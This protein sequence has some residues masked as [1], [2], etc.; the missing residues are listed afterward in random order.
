MQAPDD[1]PEGPVPSDGPPP[2]E[3]PPTEPSPTEK[4]AP[5]A[6]DRLRIEAFLEMLGAEGGV[7]DNTLIAYATDLADAAI[8]LKPEGGLATAGADGLSRYLAALE[9]RGLAPWTQARRL[10]ALR[11][12]FRFMVSDGRRPD[13]PTD[14]LDAPRRHRPLPRMLS[15]DDVDRLINAAHA[16]EGPEGRRLAAIVE[17]LYATGL[18]V[19]ELVTLPAAALIRDPRVLMVRGKGGRDRIVPLGA[20]ARAAAAA[21]LAVRGVFL[22]AD[23]KAQSFLFPSRAAEGHLTRQ[24]IGQLLKALALD[25]GIAPERVSP[26]VLRHAFASHLLSGGADLRVVQQLL[27]HADITTTQIYTHVLDADLR[28]AIERAHPLA[29]AGRPGG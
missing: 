25:A 22:P 6:A 12:F 15:E 8:T 14:R 10:S 2:T 24:R 20:P 1:G 4:P 26:H 18:R 5:L 16:M 3:P 9:A 17:L 27:G 19:S 23:R 7:A 29:G 21:Y 13:Q 28:R 11:R